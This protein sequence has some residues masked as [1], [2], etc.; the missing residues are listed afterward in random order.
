MA[1]QKTRINNRRDPRGSAEDA[2]RPPGPGGLAT[3]ARGRAGGA[4]GPPD[5]R[6]GLVHRPNLGRGSAVRAWGHREL[7][8]GCGNGTRPRGP[9]LRPQAAYRLTPEW[10]SFPRKR[11]S[12][13]CHARSRRPA[14]VEGEGPR[15]GGAPLP[16]RPCAHT[17]R[18]RTWR[19]EAAPPPARRPIPA[20]RA[21]GR[22]WTRGAAAR[23]AGGEDPRGPDPHLSSQALVAPTAHRSSIAHRVIIF[24]LRSKYSSHQEL[25]VLTINNNNLRFVRQRLTRSVIRRLII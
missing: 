21:P 16:V 6:E 18:D 20:R 5:R 4:L 12:P 11:S 7:S 25:A 17:H 23:E 10:R 1:S 2:P 19:T 22:A 13:A 14:P 8:P 15:A 24:L 9:D 3:A